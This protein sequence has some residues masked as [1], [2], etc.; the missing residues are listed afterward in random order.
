MELQEQE[1]SQFVKEIAAIFS[2]SGI[3]A[4]SKG[5][6]YREEQQKMAVA[7][8]AA[9]EDKETLL[10]EAGTGVGKSLAYLIPAVKYALQQETKAIISTHTIN[11]QEQLIT[12][13]IPLLRQLLDWDFNAILLKGRNNYLCQRRLK[14]ALSQGADLYTA[15]EM[16]EL[17]RIAEWA[18]TTT[19]GTLTDLEKR[20]LPK[21]WAQVC[22]EPHLCT[23]RSCGGNNP[24]FYQEAK[25]EAEQS[26]LIV[27]NHTLF[28]SLL[29]KRQDEQGNDDKGFLF[30]NDFVIFD[31]AHTLEQVAASQLGL[32]LSHSGL[33]FDIQRFFNL[34]TEKGILKSLRSAQGISAVKETIE[35]AE[36][37]FIELSM[38]AEFG[39]KGREWRVREAGLIENTLAEPLENL[40][41]VL[42]NQ[43]ERLN[44][45]SNDW[46]E[47]KDGAKK[48]REASTAI[49]SFLNQD[50][51][52]C[53]YWIERGGRENDE[54]SVHSAPINVAERLQSIVFDTGQ[55]CVMTSATLG[56]GDENLL[57]FKQRVGAE[58][59]RTVQLGSPFDYKKQMEIFI[60]RS[61][62]D[63][64]A[65]NYKKALIGW[66]KRVITYTKGKA[67]VLFT[68]YRLMH[69]VAEEMEDFFTE[70]GW[71]LFVQGQG[72]SP[73]KMV[74]AFRED[75]HSVLFGTD[76]FWAG[77]DVPGESLSNVIV[78]RLPFAVPNNPVVE[79]KLEAITNTGGNAFMEY[80]VPEA[81]IKL[82]QGVGRLIRS[83][84]DSGMVVILDN[85]VLTKFYGQKFLDALPD[86]SRKIV[87]ETIV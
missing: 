10:A 62:P 53:V 56:V 18:Q 85:R 16:T 19:N 30:D 3:L 83:K 49:N 80:S 28:F 13:D 54:V 5:F 9:L 63:P 70:K 65:E 58:N 55:S 57:Y 46:S 22:S 42:E 61:M 47:L 40:A 64:K 41:N 7:V 81:I 84:H 68:N 52:E 60:M 43:A 44:K 21:V 6:T 69:D 86:A 73:N 4:E 37:F 82:R 11:L 29:A 31:E 34:K 78:T 77:V 12:K 74:K 75:L 50:D 67:F 38:L 20:P 36:D 35:A 14:L 79:S 39:N 17:K 1:N 51:A 24:C 45:E 27:V 2:P 23:L 48:M 76:S 33:R 59:A 26:D 87:N 8:A 66:L 32:R 71:N 25:K 15:A 72:M